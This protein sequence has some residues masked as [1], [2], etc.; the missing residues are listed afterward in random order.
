MPQF[1]SLSYLNQ[2]IWF[3]FVF[4]SFYFMMTYFFLPFLCKILKFRKKKIT[5]NHTL[6][7]KIFSE[8]V[9]ENFPANANFKKRILGYNLQLKTLYTSMNGLTFCF[10]TE[11][12]GISKIKL[13]LNTF[14]LINLTT[15]SLFK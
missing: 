11:Y 3:M 14:W 2:V 13:P 4:L 7:S 6:I 5:N 8:Y 10:F 1:D 9:F 12:C 15:V